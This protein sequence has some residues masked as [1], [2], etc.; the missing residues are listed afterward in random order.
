MGTGPGGWLSSCIF[1]MD[2]EYD[3]YSTLMQEK[4]D[5]SFSSTL[6]PVAVPYTDVRGPDLNLG[7]TEGEEYPL[8]AECDRVSLPL[9]RFASASSR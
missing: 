8:E 3:G 7:Q 5:D 1:G 4:D 6:R 2:V 9:D